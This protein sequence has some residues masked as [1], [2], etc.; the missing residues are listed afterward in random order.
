M[1]GLQLKMLPLLIGFVGAALACYT[2]FYTIFMQG[3]IGK[4]G[5]TVAVSRSVFY[6][7]CPLC[8]VCGSM[9]IYCCKM[10][11]SC[12]HEGIAN[13]RSVVIT[14]VMYNHVM[15]ESHDMI[16]YCRINELHSFSCVY[17]YTIGIMCSV[18]DCRI[19]FSL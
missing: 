19:P 4:N 14:V 13:P 5:S 9:C 10:S 12:R 3:G 11:E 16:G 8:C 7:Q 17:V 1:I 15:S 6:T 18:S 2:N